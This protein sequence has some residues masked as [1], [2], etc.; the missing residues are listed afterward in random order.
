[1]IFKTEQ[2]I[3]IVDRAHFRDIN[4]LPH[5]SGVELIRRHC[6]DGSGDIEATLDPCT[7]ALHVGVDDGCAVF[8]IPSDSIETGH[9][10]WA[11]RLQVSEEL[12]KLGIAQANCPH[13]AL[14]AEF[15]APVRCCGDGC[16]DT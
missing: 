10:P 7:K 5:L 15:A 11:V 3:A 8:V 1:M 14:P 4:Y 2:T 9:S 6:H 12:K 13:P 16:S